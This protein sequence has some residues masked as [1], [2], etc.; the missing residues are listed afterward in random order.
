MVVLRNIIS[1]W[2]W[3]TLVYI[4]WVGNNL[5]LKFMTFV[6]RGWSSSYISFLTGTP[7]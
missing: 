6:P 4:F 3:G 7:P 5:S 1:S 2:C